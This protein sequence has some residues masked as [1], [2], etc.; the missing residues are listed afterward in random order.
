MIGKP[1][2][3]GNNIIATAVRNEIGAF[4]PISFQFLGLFCEIIHGFIGGGA[5]SDNNTSN[6]FDAGR[7][8]NVPVHPQAHRERRG[9]SDGP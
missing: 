8:R 9:R 6:T 3:S 5:S 4:F 7:R 2:A 1:Q